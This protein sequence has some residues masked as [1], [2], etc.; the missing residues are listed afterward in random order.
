MLVRSFV[1]IASIGLI[2]QLLLIF[3]ILKCSLHN[4]LLIRG[5]NSARRLILLMTFSLAFPGYVKKKF[6]FNSVSEVRSNED[7]MRKHTTICI[8]PNQLLLTTL[9]QIYWPFKIEIMP[10]REIETNATYFAIRT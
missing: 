9:L 4:V 1:H 8:F 10:T 5:S 7:R 3:L 2:L 6:G